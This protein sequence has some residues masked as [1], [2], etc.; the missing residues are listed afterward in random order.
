MILI[1]LNDPLLIIDIVG[2]YLSNAPA[3]TIDKILNLNYTV[4]KTLLVVVFIA[5]FLRKLN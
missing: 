1:G 4:V 5:R 3:T 2:S